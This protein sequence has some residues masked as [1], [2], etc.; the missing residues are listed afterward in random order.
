MRL[1]I[2]V[3]YDGDQAETLA[4]TPGD[5]VKF[6]R[7]TEKSM[8]DA[9]TV[10]DITRLAYIAAR[11]KGEQRTFDEWVDGLVDIDMGE[12]DTPPLTSTASPSS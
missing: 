10:S 1:Q 7:E 5:M 8:A 6:E 3:V 9:A 12:V 2:N 11:R 4:I